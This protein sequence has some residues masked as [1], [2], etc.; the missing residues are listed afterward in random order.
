MADDQDYPVG[1]GFVAAAFP[2]PLLL[3]VHIWTIYRD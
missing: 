2:T 3:K 1:G